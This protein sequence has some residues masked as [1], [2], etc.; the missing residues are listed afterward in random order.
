[1][2]RDYLVIHEYETVVVWSK[3]GGSVVV[4]CLGYPGAKGLSQVPWWGLR[5]N[6]QAM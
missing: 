3:E 5:G 4:E 2:C 1:M 6:M